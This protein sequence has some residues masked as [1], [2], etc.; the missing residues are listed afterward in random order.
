MKMV[1]AVYNVA[2]DD[3]VMEA[4]RKAGVKCFTKWPHI[5]GEGQKTGPRMDNHT[6]PGANCA[7][8]MVVPD[9]LVGRVMGA[10]GGL[11]E[12]IGQREGIKAFVLNVEQQL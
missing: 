8:M 12:T 2:V 7:T 5:L 11:R 10:I 6:W 9:E 4:V 1:L 3:E